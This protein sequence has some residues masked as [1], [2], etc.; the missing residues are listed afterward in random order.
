MIYQR[1][2]NQRSCSRLQS[3]V[4]VVTCS[5]LLVELV[6]GVTILEPEHEQDPSSSSTT[7]TTTRV[8]PSWD[9]L[10]K[11][12]LPEWYDDAKFG[13]FIHWGVFSV[14]SY[15]SEWF[16]MNWKG[17]TSNENDDD[18]ENV[19]NDFVINTERK[20]FTYQEYASRFHA[21]LYR[22]Q[23]WAT[24]FAQSGA[25]YVVVTSKHHDGYCM[26]FF[27]RCFSLRT[28]YRKNDDSHRFVV[29]TKFLFLPNYV[30]IY[31]YILGNW[32]SKNVTTTW[33]WNVMDIGPHR[34]ILGDLAKEIR[35]VQSDQTNQTLKFGIYHSLYEWYNPM[36]INDRKNQYTTQQFVVT[37]TLPE[38]YDLVQQYQPE[39]IWSDGDW[40]ASSDYWLSRE[41][42]HWYIT[43]SSVASTGV[44]ND[45]WGTD[46]NCRHG[47]YVTCSDR[48]NPNTIQTKKF[49]NALTI[50]KNS[51]G[52][53]RNSTNIASYMSTEEIIHTLIQVV[54]F[55]GNM[56]LNVGPNA[57]GTI[58]PIFLDRLHNIGKW[59]SINGVAIYGTRPWDICQNETMSSVYYTKKDNII[60]ALFVKWP[61]DNTLQL[62][63]IVPTDTTQIHFVGLEQSKNDNNDENSNNSNKLPTVV[64]YRPV[65]R[66]HEDRTTPENDAYATI[67]TNRQRSRAMSS[68]SKPTTNDEYGIEVV[69][70][71][72]TP[73]IIPCQYAWVL[74]I[75]NIKNLC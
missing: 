64:Q 1:R 10:D 51:W 5:I 70:P 66:V 38:L 22:P 55:N 36:Y 34:D 30:L 50:D 17:S 6:T 63:C 8:V 57:D 61:T 69:L 56:L 32:N 40:E 3:I 21:E 20:H 2:R 23:E 25:Q 43:N 73:D 24:I 29:L 53:N 44:Y 75:S 58:D 42:I 46:V 13:I 72:L 4:K 41:F 52:Y 12:I 14:P 26:F 62:H 48:Y 67:A 35:K 74:E 15:G 71:A 27:F 37:K 49:E 18:T 33:N 28:V 54:A 9:E 65:H 59:L 16:W 45:R 11:R 31:I 19:Y 7:T 68:S 47:S 39:I 60:Y